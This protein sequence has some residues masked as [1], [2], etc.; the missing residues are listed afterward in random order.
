MA[1]Q[2]QVIGY[3]Y[4]PPGEDGD[5]GI[6]AGITLQET[7][8]RAWCDGRGW[9]EVEVLSDPPVEPGGAQPDAAVAIER[10]R[11]E[12]AVVFVARSEALPGG[13]TQVESLIREA[14]HSPLDIVAMDLGV[15][16]TTP[17]GRV[18]A[19]YLCALAQR[20][21][22]SAATDLPPAELRYRVTGVGNADWFDWS[23]YRTLQDYESALSGM[24]RSLE[25][26]GALLDFGCGCGRVMR[27]LAA[28][29]PHTALT[30]VDIDASATD[31]L[32]AALPDAD[33]RATQGLPPLPFA[34]GSFD[35]VLGC[36]VFSH[37]DQTY[38][39]A[40]LGE[41]QR[42]TKPG[43]LLLLTVNG[44][45]SF[46]WHA[47]GPMRGL[48]GMARLARQFKRKG[49][50]FWEGDGWER[51]FPDFYHSAWHKP[52]YIHKHWKKWFRVRSVL[53]G[54]AG[55]LQDLVVLER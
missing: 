53:E 13:L 54:K 23:G 19:D 25:D 37:L 55:S 27:Y 52:R 48:D 40:W 9:T 4:A 49:F 7:A 39:D 43:A 47:T 24:G 50:L 17:G 1:A 3:A 5:S 44:P 22:P 42:V 10:A 26:F 30:G 36:S 31:W 41:L 20:L 35:L 2:R 15:D 21:P 38:Q 34:D 45:L 33:V 6:D 11:R 51:W 16:T 46:E 29:L 8:M 14:A 18:V 32:A 12:G 28:R